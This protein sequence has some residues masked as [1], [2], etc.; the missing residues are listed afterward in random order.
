MRLVQALSAVAAAVVAAPSCSNNAT[1]TTVPV[2]PADA[3]Q[4]L[5]ERMGADSGNCEQF[6]QPYAECTLDPK[7]QQAYDQQ[8]A[9]DAGAAWRADASTGGKC[10]PSWPSA[11]VTVTCTVYGQY[12]TGRRSV[13]VVQLRTFDCLSVGEYLAASAYLEAASV[14][15]FSRLT[16]ELV[17]HRAPS[18]LVHATRSARRDE[19]R[20]T[21]LL[22]RQA[23]RFGVI[24]RMPTAHRARDVR[25][26]FMVARE[27][28]VEGC[29][30]ETLGAT[31]NL[32]QAEIAVDRELRTTMRSIA[33][34]ECRH[35]DLAWGVAEW[36]L[37]R[38]SR[39][40]RRLVGAAQQAE[41]AAMRRALRF[42]GVTPGGARI[43]GL[44]NAAQRDL[45]VTLLNPLMND[46]TRGS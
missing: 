29:V 15:A 17:A 20:H 21:R 5:F 25:S 33:A 19:V 4:L 31:M 13:D 44:P 22:G 18:S 38:L 34:D 14:H 41:V 46:V 12:G 8:N 16:R 28:A 10:C 40:Q 37:P 39:G 35:A 1:V 2:T 11:T 27:N 45:L 26:L 9:A 30:R 23:K 42:N 3:C 36:A 7:Y 43:L 32:L 6:C 24:A